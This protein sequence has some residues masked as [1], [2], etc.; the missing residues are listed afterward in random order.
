[1]LHLE[2]TEN[3]F[4]IGI[5]MFSATFLIG[6]TIHPGEPEKMYYRNGDGYPGSPPSCEILQITCTDID[7]IAHGGIVLASIKQQVAKRLE[8]RLETDRQ[9][10]QDI[11]DR[12][13]ENYHQLCEGD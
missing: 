9:L 1:M 7:G 6:F 13:F 4:P 5:E 8:E 3:E 2:W 10:R 12:C 11:C